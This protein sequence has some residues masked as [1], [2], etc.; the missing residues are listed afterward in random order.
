MKLLLSVEWNALKATSSG[1][2]HRNDNGDRSIQSALRSRSVGSG[3]FHQKTFSASDTRDFEITHIVVKVLQKV[4][5]GS[6][7]SL[8]E[9]EHVGLTLEWLGRNG[10]WCRMKFRCAHASKF[11][12]ED[13]QSTALHWSPII[14]ELKWKI[15]ALHVAVDGDGGW[16]WTT[17]RKIGKSTAQLH[18]SGILW[19]QNWSTDGDIRPEFVRLL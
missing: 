7:E 16:M 1:L 14:H 2:Y 12:N 10:D 9:P 19:R 4:L 11:K 5:A 8:P 13:R 6:A 18:D 15:I 3:T 17:T